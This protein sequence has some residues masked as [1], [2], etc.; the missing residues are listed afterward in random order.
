MVADRAQRK[1]F[2]VVLP[3]T[4]RPL[5]S[6]FHTEPLP[7]PRGHSSRQKDPRFARIDHSDL[8]LNINASSVSASPRPVL[9]PRALCPASRI[10]R[11]PIGGL[12]AALIGASCVQ[13]GELHMTAR[14]Y[15]AKTGFPVTAYLVLRTLLTTR[16]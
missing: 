9:T 5:V 1:R 8:T 2:H 7:P 16:R 4:L 11:I 15:V 12:L 6:S 3:P 14:L 13:R 10:M